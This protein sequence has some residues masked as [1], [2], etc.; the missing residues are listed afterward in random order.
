ML[1]V[2]G[3]DYTTTSVLI[4]PLSVDPRWHFW[5]SNASLE[6]HHCVT[7]AQL[8]CVLLK[9][10]SLL[11]A[12]LSRTPMRDQKKDT[13]DA[14]ELNWERFFRCGDSLFGDLLIGASAVRGF[15]SWN[16]CGG[17]AN[18]FQVDA[19]SSNILIKLYTWK[20]ENKLFAKRK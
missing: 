6:S 15:L 9:G 5:I 12:S 19:Q 16:W 18:F 1:H 14:L 20:V 11:A 7:R 8:Y 10:I 2:C 17:N 4:R 13:A 3:A